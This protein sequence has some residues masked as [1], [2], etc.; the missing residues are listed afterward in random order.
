VWFTFALKILKAG[1]DIMRACLTTA[2]P[3]RLAGDLTT[4]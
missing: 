2:A 4:L 3:M 1:D